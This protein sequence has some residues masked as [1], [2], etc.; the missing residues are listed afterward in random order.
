MLS[1]HQKIKN[2][3]GLRAIAVLLVVVTHLLPIEEKYAQFDFILP[4][5]LMIGA[6]GVDLFFL[7]SGFVMVAVTRNAF[8]SQSA[9]KHFI[10]HR[11]TRIY[12][13]YWFY[14]ILILG[15]YLIQPTLV[16]SS[17]GNQVNILAS[18]L[19]LPQT[20]LPLVNVGWTLIHEIYFYI[21]FALLLFLPKKT[22]LWSLIMWGTIVV[23][24]HYIFAD[25]DNPF[26]HFYFH[27]LTLEFIA[28]SL[29]AIRY[30]D[31]TLY[32]NAKFFAIVA[33]LYWLGTYFLFQ[34]YTGE[35][36]P[37]DGLR[38][39]IFGIPAGLFLYATL[40]YEK[41]YG[42]IMPKWL[43]K[44]GD[45][46]YSIYLSHIIVLTI[47]GRAWFLFAHETYW[48]NILMLV[49][50]LISVLF[51]GYISYYFIEHF[52]LNSTKKLARLIFSKQI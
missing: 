14:S 37:L 25:S 41:N 49:I 7:I 52:L 18:F 21:I 17:Q 2:I 8:E 23:I 46:S 33:V 48:D 4:Q 6:S 26:I 30:Y 28:G 44:I 20:L 43:C 51:S 39:I 42:I 11:I 10:Y 22:L 24:G 5:F 38:V 45:A 34:H 36:L 47:V 40:L 50:M 13:L 15:V 3:Q 16:N 27:P 12:P 32:G 35:I 9:I 31:H 19:L 29:I 1:S